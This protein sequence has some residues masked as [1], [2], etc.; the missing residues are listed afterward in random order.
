MR[1]DRAPEP[2]SAGPTL[3]GT[4]A[5]RLL[6]A[7][8]PGVL[9]L[10]GLSYLEVRRI[11]A[12][13]RARVE[14]LA[15][16]AA[17]RRAEEGLAAGILRRRL[18]L[19]G[20]ARRLETLSRAAARSAGDSLRRRDRLAGPDD[21]LVR[22]EGGSLSGRSS[23]GLAAVAPLP[24]VPLSV[25]LD[26]LAGTRAAA[27][28]LGELLEGSEEGTSL[29]VATSR[30]ALRRI[31]AGERGL[32]PGE[33][34][35]AAFTRAFEPAPGAAGGPAAWRT[36]PGPA[37][38]PGDVEVRAGA[39]FALPD[40][41]TGRAEAAVRLASLLSQTGPLAGGVPTV[42][43]LADPVSA[44]TVSTAAP[45]GQAE[46][47]L[48]PSDLR[49]LERIAGADGGARSV[50]LSAGRFHA[51]ARRVAG[52]GWIVARLVPSG[53]LRAEAAAAAAAVSGPTSGS[54]VRVF[55]LQFAGLIA[56]ALALVGLLS[57]L[58]GPLRNAADYADALAGGREAPPPPP[59]ERDDE[60]GRVVR[61]LRDL[62]ERI[63]RRS[64]LTEGGHDLA[65]AASLM[66]R[67]EE[68]LDV[69]SSRIAS[70]VGAR[71]V[72]FLL[73]DPSDRTLG[74]ARRA[75]DPA[76]AGAV[77]ERIGWDDHSLAMLSYRSGETFVSDDVKNDPKTSSRFGDA[78]VLREN[79]LFTPLRTE[80]GSL[81]VLLVGDKPGGFDRDDRAA[82]E[83]WA[84]TASLLLRNARLY[85]ELQKGAD[86]LQ[87]A[88]QSR[89]HF[90]Q[91]VNHEL[92]T[93]LTA[94]VG[95]AEVLSE[96][97][98]DE[99]TA[100]AAVEQ[101]R[102]SAGHLVTLVSDL[103]DLARL[104]EGASRIERRPTDLPALVL[105]VVDALDVLA[106]AK[107]ST[108]E[109]DL[110]G[111]SLPPVTLDPGRTRQVLWNLVHNALK[112]TPAGG[113]VVVSARVEDGTAVL[114]VADEGPGIPE[115]DLPWI[116]ERWRQSDAAKVTPQRGSGIGLSLARGF[117]EA[118]G[119]TI[120]VRNSPGRGATFVVRIPPR[121][122]S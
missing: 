120:A 40:G 55:G 52:P 53:A 39:A 105:S 43:F 117:V 54:L 22:Q 118:H 38:A 67:P 79:V 3:R 101:I 80:V 45:P 86:R 98:P 96:D 63:R 2:P 35:P 74:A 58:L 27:H 83:A 20:R 34:D 21:V 31:P 97:R 107:G 47:V 119:G 10:W 95:W 121:S 37:D 99:A 102:R 16:D 61:S 24:A 115:R 25:A 94:I 5:F 15:G 75:E 17:L 46:I 66:T 70:L 6:V 116:F 56:A 9:L 89:E 87:R 19:T 51:I 106:S 84:D 103:L 81:G 71:R 12:D 57:R 100:S 65:R 30:G 92:R 36:V 32:F 112:F 49:I 1:G 23:T 77:E 33:L 8:V 13:A 111:G 29:Y 28:R 48:S 42:E 114:S 82:I 26:D 93:P 41:A 90:L 14:S 104:E 108:L 76:G 60:V 85:D 69:L 7:L 91:D 110:P 11:G 68:T 4:V 64:R 73:F 59:V 78:S 88:I 113:R 122:R 18:E 50:D 72:Q 62:G 44:A 109:A